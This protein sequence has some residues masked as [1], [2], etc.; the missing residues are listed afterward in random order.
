MAVAETDIT[1]SMRGAPSPNLGG[2]AEGRDNNLNLLRALAAIGV[3]VSHAWPLAMGPDSTAPLKSI[4]GINLG[5]VCV[6][7]FFAIS[8]FL[9]TE[10]LRRSKGYGPWLIARGLRILPGLFVAVALCALVLG[11]AVSTLT[12]NDY[13]SE[14]KVWSYIARNATILW[15]QPGL[16]G[17]FETVPWFATVNGSI[18][19]LYGE[20]LCYAAVFAI[21]PLTLRFGAA[22]LVAGAAVFIAFYGIV[23]LNGAKYQWTYFNRGAVDYGLAFALGVCASAMKNRLTI[24][25]AGCVYMGLALAVCWTTRIQTEMLL[26]CLV[27]W[28]FYLG[29][30]PGGIIRQYNYV[31]DYSYGLYIYAFPIQQLVGHFQGIH[32]PWL[33]IGI[34]LP[35]SLA[36][37]VVSWH[38]IEQPSLALKRRLCRPAFSV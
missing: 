3:L 21:G 20:V 36:L 27:Y 22:P 16:P 26:T 2:L 17:V 33:N 13:F 6:I 4:L 11:P 23:T 29:Y 10:S 7:V 15:Q 32:S 34:A 14:P 1:R 8:G 19:T 5:S 30:V 9:V 18:W 35:A 37:A 25:G 31:G 12:A 24:S 28:S 38:V